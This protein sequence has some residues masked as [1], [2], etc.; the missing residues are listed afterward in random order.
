MDYIQN[1]AGALIVALSG[2][3]DLST[4][5]I[6]LINKSCLIHDVILLWSVH[7]KDLFHQISTKHNS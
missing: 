2:Q 1:Y 5:F 7:T 6:I 4:S 3:D